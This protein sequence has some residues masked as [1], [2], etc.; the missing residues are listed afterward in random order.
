M[1]TTSCSKC[2]KLSVPLNRKCTRCQ[3][4]EVLCCSRACQTGDWNKHKKTCPG[5]QAAEKEKAA[6][7]QGSSLKTWESLQ[8]AERLA[9]LL[10]ALSTNEDVYRELIYLFDQGMTV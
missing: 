10:A 9:E 6:T 2:Q 3:G 8:I 4:Q 5:I 7:E 1:P